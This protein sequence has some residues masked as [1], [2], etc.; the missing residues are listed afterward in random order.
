MLDAAANQFQSTEVIGGCMPERLYLDYNCFQRGFDDQRQ[1]RIR[2]EADACE[3]IFEIAESGAI[4]LVWSFMHAD[5][6]LLC[7]FADRKMEVARLAR[8]CAVRIGPDDRIRG[9]AKHFVSSVGL[10][11]KDAL[12]LAAAECA[13]S[14]WFVTCDDDLLKRASALA[15][16]SRVVNPVSYVMSRG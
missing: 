9:Q 5:E 7:P 1:A 11:P 16:A 4:E 2:M 10:S 13:K 8:V 12:H 14:V 6:N 15:V 3:E